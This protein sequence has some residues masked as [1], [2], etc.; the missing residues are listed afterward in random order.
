MLYFLRLELTGPDRTGRPGRPDS[1]FSG[2]TDLTH[3]LGGSFSHP[4]KLRVA[5]VLHAVAV[6]YQ[7]SL[8]PTGPYL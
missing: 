2:S 6:A 4:T 1:S 3:M 8:P 7:T 5:T